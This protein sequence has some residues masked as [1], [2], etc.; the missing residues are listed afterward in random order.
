MLVVSFDVLLHGF[1]RE[2]LAL[3]E[4][5]GQ[6]GRVRRRFVGGDRVRR[7]PGVLESGAEESRCRFGVA[8]LPEQHF[9]DLPVLIDG[10]VDITPAPGDFDVGLILS[11]KSGG[12]SESGKLRAAC[13]L[14]WD[15]IQPIHDSLDIDRCGRDGLLQAGFG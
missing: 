11:A 2:V 15:P 5:F 3:R 9:N 12:E 13:F 8:V 6:S 4:D 1:S 10:P 14:L 7:H